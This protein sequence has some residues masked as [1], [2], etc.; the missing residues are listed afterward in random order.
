MRVLRVGRHRRYGRGSS[1]EFVSGNTS[2]EETSD[3]SPDSPSPDNNFGEQSPDPSSPHATP[4]NAPTPPMPLPY[5]RFQPSS[6]SAPGAQLASYLQQGLTSSNTPGFFRIISSRNFLGNSQNTNTGSSPL[7]IVGIRP[8]SSDG[9]GSRTGSPPQAPSLQDLNSLV[10]SFTSALNGQSSETSSNSSDVGGHEVQ[11]T[12]TNNSETQVPSSSSPTSSSSS[13]SAST[14]TPAPPSSGYSILRNLFPSFQNP[15]SQ[16][17]GAAVAAELGSTSS[18]SSSIFNV[19]R[20]ILPLTSA[21]PP[22]TPQSR[23]GLPELRERWMLYIIAFPGP[24]GN[25]TTDP[26]PPNSSQDQ[27]NIEQNVDST[28]TNSA[29]PSNSA[30]SSSNNQ[31]SPEHDELSDILA[32]LI[33][34]LFSAMLPNSGE[35]EAGLDGYEQLLRLAELV[36]SARPRNIRNREQLES[37]VPIVVYDRAQIEEELSKIEFEGIAERGGEED[38]RESEQE[39]IVEER[40][41]ANKKRKRTDTGKESK[42]KQKVQPQASRK[43]ARLEAVNFEGTLEEKQKQVGAQLIA[44]SLGGTRERCSICLADYADGDELRMLTCRHAFHKNCFDEWVVEY[45]NSCPICRVKCVDETTQA[46]T[47]TTSSNGQTRDGRR[48]NIFLRVQLDRGI[49]SGGARGRAATN[50]GQQQQQEMS[51]S[52]QASTVQSDNSQA[53]S[54]TRW[55]FSWLFGSDSR[56]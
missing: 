30:A 53:S 36:G 2:N 15:N 20:P 39:D 31:E 25:E 13:T 9:A 52:S 41:T 43:R 28:T 46:G 7:F 33:R 8:L 27:S 56:N 34:V 23:S 12:D 37:Q 4:T 40:L 55:P 5:P 50:V 51:S 16:S 17:N 21:N 42:G 48:P 10:S 32:R 11:A 44:L 22:R 14:S 54:G 38:G 49:L 45:V 26:N 35:A 19:F 29:A 3:S 6:P 24:I 18:A 1:E 47:G